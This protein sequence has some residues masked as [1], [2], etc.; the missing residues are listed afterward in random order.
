MT[1][2]SDF[3]LSMN[4]GVSVSENYLLN[5]YIAKECYEEI[6]ESN[7]DNMSDESMFTEFLDIRFDLASSD[8]PTLEFHQH[9]CFDLIMQIVR[10]ICVGSAK[11]LLPPLHSVEQCLHYQSC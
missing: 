9:L 7:L 3:G 6:A 5:M 8:H 1:E 11:D 2:L 10:Q 4:K